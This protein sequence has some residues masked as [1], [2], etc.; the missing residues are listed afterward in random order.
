MKRILWVLIM[1]LGINNL[2]IGQRFYEVKFLRSY[3]NSLMMELKENYGNANYSYIDYG[4]LRTTRN[5]L[6]GTSNYLFQAQ[7]Y[8][9]L[10][11]VSFYPSRI[12]SAEAKRFFQV[13]PA[14]QYFSPYT[15]VGND[16]VNFIDL[17]GNIGKPLVLYEEHIGL[18]DGMTSNLL[19]LKDQ[20]PDA[21]YRPISDLVN[22]E[23]T[24][25]PDWNGTVF[26]QG[27]MNT[28]PGGGIQVERADNPLKLKAMSRY[29]KVK[30]GEKTKT[31]SSYISGRKISPMLKKMSLKLRRPIKTVVAGGCEGAVAA[32][33]MRSTFS[34]PIRGVPNIFEGQEVQFLGAKEHNYVM[35]HGK[36]VTDHSPD[37]AGLD[38]TR[39]SIDPHG[40]ENKVYT[41]ERD[42]V[43][44]FDR[45]LSK[46]PEG[47]LVTQPYAEG[48]ELSRF[49]KEGRAPSGLTDFYSQLKG[50]Y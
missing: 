39:L 32:E 26:I 9:D 5:G 18:K 47:N 45:M 23:I 43:T 16:P 13:D 44:Y 6:A 25:L 10:L 4:K 15:F 38:H 31:Y 34:D 22:E 17:D 7:E 50:V 41:T 33:G 42:G 36:R 28:W 29:A 1:F 11:G 40:I 14:S 12:Y 21:H 48:E 46:T 19:D 30:F 27:H 20:V 3:N 8:D 35:F 37:Y 49:I 2:S 24:S